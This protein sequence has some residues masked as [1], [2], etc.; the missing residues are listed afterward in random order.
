MVSSSYPG[1]IVPVAVS[2]I[3]KSLDIG[4][5]YR[6]VLASEIQNIRPGLSLAPLL[7]NGS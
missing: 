3:G 2:Q 6:E 4:V 7:S 5:E 1:K